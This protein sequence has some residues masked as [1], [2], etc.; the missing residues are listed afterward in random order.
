ML[1]NKVARV[2]GFAGVCGV[3]AMIQACTPLNAGDAPSVEAQDGVAPR[4]GGGTVAGAGGPC[5]PPGLPSGTTAGATSGPMPPDGYRAKWTV[6][7]TYVE[8]DLKM[9]NNSR[10]VRV[11][12]DG[13]IPI[14]RV[15]PVPGGPEA[16]V[17][18]V[19]PASLLKPINGGKAVESTPRGRIQVEVYKIGQI[20][21]TKDAVGNVTQWVVSSW[22]LG[23]AVRQK[24]GRM[25]FNDSCFRNPKLVGKDTMGR[26]EEGRELAGICVVEDVN[27]EYNALSAEW[28]WTPIWN[29]ATGNVPMKNNPSSHPHPDGAYY[30][31]YDGTA[32]IFTYYSAALNDIN[33]AERDWLGGYYVG[34]GWCHYIVQGGYEVPAAKRPATKSLPAPGVINTGSFVT[35]R[36]VNPNLDIAN[37][38]EP[39]SPDPVEPAPEPT[40][41]AIPETDTAPL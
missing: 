19:K 9:R 10:I 1:T 8:G 15:E 31:G 5:A 32:N 6:C 28:G 37:D 34:D 22:D 30:K 35:W 38:E 16:N 17:R 25:V 4:C 11:A 3:F 36:P 18:R 33:G 29:F 12:P 26:V 40:D 24:D 21:Q 13:T 2:L 14:M 23:Q 27:Q 41:T 7:K 39:A 20:I